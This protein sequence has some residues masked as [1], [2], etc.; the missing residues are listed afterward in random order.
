MNMSGQIVK[1]F[2]SGKRSGG[3]FVCCTLSPRGDWIYCVGEDHVLYCFSVSTGK[4]ERTLTVHEKEVIG[5]SHHPHQ[6]LLSTFSEDGSLKLWKLWKLWKRAQ[7]KDPPITCSE[8][9]ATQIKLILV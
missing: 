1:S 9:L 2:S 4:L 3:D 8:L 6:N 7:E 5:I